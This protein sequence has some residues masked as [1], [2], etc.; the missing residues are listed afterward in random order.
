MMSQGL[1]DTVSGGTPG[2]RWRHALYG[3]ERWIMRVTRCI[4]IA[5]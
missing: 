5:L 2:F 3:S 1:D 4:A